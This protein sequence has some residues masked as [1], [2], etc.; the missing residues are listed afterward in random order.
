MKMMPLLTR[1]LG[2]MVLLM[3]SLF[4]IEVPP[5]PSVFS[6]SNEAG[7]IVGQSFAIDKDGFVTAEHVWEKHQPLFVNGVPIEILA[8][9]SAADLLYFSL[10]SQSGKI[11]DV[12]SFKQS[13]I[14]NRETLQWKN[15]SGIVVGLHVDVSIADRA[16]IDLIELKGLVE[17]GDSGLPV[18][19]LKNKVV[20]MIVGGGEGVVYV[21]RIKA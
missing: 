16:Y 9:D 7:L 4:F 13:P 12:A 10:S 2:V 19:D 3:I 5:V 20:G 11:L 21:V 14:I 18:Y 15:A 6:L 1:F 8:R 17:P